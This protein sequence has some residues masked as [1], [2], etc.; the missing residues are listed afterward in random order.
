METQEPV[1]VS[2]ASA[3]LASVKQSRTRL[4]WAGYPAWYW[5][6][7]ATAWAV[8]PLAMLLPAWAGLACVGVVAVAVLRLTVAAGRA[9][10]VCE[11]WTRS[12]MRWPEV[13]LLYGPA[14]AVLL[15]SAFI[16]RSTWW[17]TIVG[18]VLVFVLFA[19]TAL[20]LSARAARR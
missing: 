13:T 8:L 10:G 3:A 9:R 14:T 11:G 17:L 15:A 7:T 5:L 12:A 4:A 2:E 18:A 16:P 1:G 19:G 20:A 6:G